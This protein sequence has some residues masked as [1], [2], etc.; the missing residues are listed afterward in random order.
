MNKKTAASDNTRK[1][2]KEA[3]LELYADGGISG[4]TVGAITKKA[5]Y[6]RSTFY[7]YYDDITSMLDEI[8]N[9]L[10]ADMKPK[11]TKAFSNG[12]PMDLNAVFPMMFS[13]FEQYSYT[14]YILLVRN[15]NIDFRKRLKRMLQE[16]LKEAFKDHL[17]TEQSEYVLTFVVSSG[18]G[19]IEYWYETD[20]KSSPEDFMTI[21]H[22]LIANGV[23]GQLSG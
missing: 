1:K 14:L 8:E 5:G 4:I 7:N 6:N 9:T 3:F 12:I 17:S 23:F 11:I 15:S 18:L 2:L 10:I 16:P 19:L 22:S 13:V 20:K 21:C